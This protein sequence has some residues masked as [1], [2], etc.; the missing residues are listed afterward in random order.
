MDKEK[1]L[2]I[3]TLLHSGCFITFELSITNKDKVEASPSTISH[4][5][6]KMA[7]FLLITSAFIYK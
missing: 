3:A 6:A 5:Y 7:N 1:K 2:Q 4:S